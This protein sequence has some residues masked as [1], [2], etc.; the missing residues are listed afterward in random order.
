M[1][2][3][4]KRWAGFLRPTFTH[5]NNHNKRRLFCFSLSANCRVSA[6]A[7]P[8]PAAICRGPSIIHVGLGLGCIVYP[9]IGYK[10]T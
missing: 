9:T 7:I 3:I 5:A 6:E 10:L 4:T 2:P 1:T 8:M